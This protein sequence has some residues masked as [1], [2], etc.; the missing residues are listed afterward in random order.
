[1]TTARPATKT[2]FQRNNP[3]WLEDM[4]TD[5]ERMVRDTAPF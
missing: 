5:D 4:L 1:M 3:L 2:A